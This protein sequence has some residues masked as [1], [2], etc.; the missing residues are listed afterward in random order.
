MGDLCVRLP[1]CHSN[2]PETEN[3]VCSESR[4]TNAD[5]GQITALTG[6]PREVVPCNR[7]SNI[8]SSRVRPQLNHHNTD[9]ELKRQADRDIIDGTRDDT[10]PTTVTKGRNDQYR[11]GQK[12]GEL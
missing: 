3:E 10:R 5:L 2:N 4:I 8:F 7:Y 9:L 6:A 11:D 12:F 1:Y